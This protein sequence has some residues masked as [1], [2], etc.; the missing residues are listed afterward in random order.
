MKDANVRIVTCTG[1]TTSDDGPR[2]PVQLVGKKKVAFNIKTE[3]DTFL[4]V[5]QEI[6]RNLG[7]MPILD[8]PFTFNPSVEVGPSRQ[9]GTLLKFF[10]IFL[11]LAR[12]LDSLIELETLMHLPKITMKDS[13][14]N[15]LQK[16][17][18]GKEMQINVQIGDY[19][20][21]S[22]ILKLGY[23]INILTKQ[24]WKSMGKPMLGWSPV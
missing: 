11:S 16:R 18:T 7:K 19:E 14:V 20:V 4:E 1:V 12:D 15:S 22:V 5:K 21:N 10:E 8:I 2:Q 24:T 6:G 3:K 13:A 9:H 23:D 17:K